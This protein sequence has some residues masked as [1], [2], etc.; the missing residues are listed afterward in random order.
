MLGP[1]LHRLALLVLANHLSSYLPP[2]MRPAGE[3]AR[4]KLSKMWLLC[5]ETIVVPL[6]PSSNSYACL[7]LLKSLW[8]KDARY[9]G[10]PVSLEVGKLHIH[11]QRDS[12][13]CQFYSLALPFLLLLTRL[14][15]VA[16]R[17]SKTSWSDFGQQSQ[18]D[19]SLLPVWSWVV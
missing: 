19:R 16:W 13:L 9:T 11:F 3:I 8:A 10:L 2:L 1:Y 14:I 18:L 5:A 6:A 12:S 15:E 17:I 4:A 7:Q